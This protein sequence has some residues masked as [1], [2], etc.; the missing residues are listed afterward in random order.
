M[1]IL[2]PLKFKPIF[3]EKLW[4]G[5]KIGKILSKQID[6]KKKIGESW[7]I[8]GLTESISIVNNGILSGSSMQE[9]IDNYSVEL[10]GNKVY[11]KF[12]NEFPLLIKFIDAQEILSVQVHPDDEFANRNYG[13]NGKNEMW[14]IVEAEKNAQIVCGFNKKINKDEFIKCL[15]SNVLDKVLNKEN[16]VEGDVF[17]IPAKRIH[18]IGEGVLL[19]EIQQSS[20][21]TFRVYDWDRIDL[22][23]TKRDLHTDLAIKVLDF[24]LRLDYKTKYNKKLNSTIELTSNQYFTTNLIW[25]DNNIERDYSKI[26]SFV[27]YICVKGSCNIIF[28]EGSERI[29]FGQ[30]ILLPAVIKKIILQTD[31]ECKILEVYI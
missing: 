1:S 23:G 18:A 31:I 21:L 14:Y 17:F 28:G 27:I 7:E 29:D 12:K 20:D 3:V 26:D 9:L 5:E 4:G 11:E 25:I 2:Y 19:A 6:F 24:E 10:L 15:N 16:A 30:V 13:K 8:C 22:N